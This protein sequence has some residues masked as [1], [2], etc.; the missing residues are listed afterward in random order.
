MYQSRWVSTMGMLLEQILW[1]IVH[2]RWSTD[3]QISDWSLPCQRWTYIWNKK[4]S[5]E[6]IWRNQTRSIKTSYINPPT[7]FNSIWKFSRGDIFSFSRLYI[8]FCMRTKNRKARPVFIKIR[9]IPYRV[10]SS[11]VPS[12]LKKIKNIVIVDNFKWLENDDRC[13]IM[14]NWRSR[15]IL[16]EWSH[17]A[18][19]KGN[20]DGE[21]NK[22][23]KLYWKVP[24]F[25]TSRKLI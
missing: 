14:E 17:A 7:E 8:Q 16:F 22:F 5:R 13:V 21:S 15:P 4:S 18:S 20:S 23:F 1:H 12:T 6:N 25:P 10:R 11:L 3:Q 9:S 2:F 24:S 19:F